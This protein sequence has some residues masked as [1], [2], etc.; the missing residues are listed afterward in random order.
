MP[1]YDNTFLVV[2]SDSTLE[3]SVNGVQ[4][5]VLHEGLALLNIRLEM[6]YL[7]PESSCQKQPC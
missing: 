7:Q 5:G 3:V 6:V 1:V 2:R 4:S